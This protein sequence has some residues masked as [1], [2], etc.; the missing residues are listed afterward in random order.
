[1]FESL[2]ENFISIQKLFNSNLMTQNDHVFESNKEILAR[3]FSY[4][5]SLIESNVLF[6]EMNEYIFNDI[7]ILK[8]F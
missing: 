3:V 5:I 1:L 8:Y 6:S 7:F 2:Q 4:T